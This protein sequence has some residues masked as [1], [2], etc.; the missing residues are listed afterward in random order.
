MYLYK[1][2]TMK[3]R[4]CLKQQNLMHIL[5]LYHPDK[6]ITIFQMFIYEVDTVSKKDKQGTLVL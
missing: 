6:N 1:I 4:Y 3:W 2:C 5:G